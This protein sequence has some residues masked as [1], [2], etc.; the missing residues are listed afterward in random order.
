ML[1]SLHVLVF[2][3]HKLGHASHTLFLIPSTLKEGVA[4]EDYHKLVRM[5]SQMTAGLLKSM[6]Y[7]GGGLL[8]DILVVFNTLTFIYISIMLIKESY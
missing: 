8:E 2:T 5:W 1:I 3:I 4:C 6:D 7:K